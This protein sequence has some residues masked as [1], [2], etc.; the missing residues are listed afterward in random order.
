MVLKIIFL[1][2]KNNR[3][4]RL[5][6]QQPLVKQLEELAER[7]KNCEIHSEPHRPNFIR[8][9]LNRFPNRSKRIDVISRIMF[10]FLFVVFNFFYWFT[11]MFRDNM[12][13]F[14]K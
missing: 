13:E 6:Q 7:L 12:E 1:N 8:R 5:Q 2:I 9:W 11:Y 14:K 10:P 4:I 3:N